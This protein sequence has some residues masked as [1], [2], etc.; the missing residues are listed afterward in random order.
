MISL[1]EV[2]RETLPPVDLMVREVRGVSLLEFMPLAAAPVPEEALVPQEDAAP[3]FAADERGAQTAAMIDA[4]REEAGAAMRRECEAE[5]AARLEAER[6][7]SQ[8]VGAEFAG[9][10]ERYFAA[11]EAEVVKLALAVARGILLREAKADPMYLLPIVRAA[12]ARVRDGS[13]SVLRVNPAE[14]PEW[15]AI[16]LADADVI[17]DAQVLPGECVLGTS[18]GRVELGIGP[19][20]AATELLF[21]D[22][23]NLTGRLEA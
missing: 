6:A 8:R 23:A 4:A 19:Q 1:F 15:A 12:L 11:A 17:A 22:L 14:A 18:V 21:D 2:S 10:R 20:M 7:R 9:E 16:G 13:K 3:H 5:F